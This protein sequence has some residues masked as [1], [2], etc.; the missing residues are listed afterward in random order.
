MTTNPD[1]LAA[2]ETVAAEA[3]FSGLV[4]IDRPGLP[5]IDRAIGLAD[6]RWQVPVRPDSIL[7]IA[8]GAKGFTALTVMSLV[9]DGHA[10]ARHHGA[11][12]PRRRPAA[13]R[14]RR[15][16]PAPA[17]PP[18]RHRRLPR[19]D[20][21]ARRH[22]LRPAGA[23]AIDTSTPRT[24]SPPSTAI[25]P[26]FP[27]DERFAYNN[28]G[29]VLLAILAE[30][31]AGVPYH[32]LVHDRV[33]APAGMV[34]TAFQRSDAPQPRTR[35]RLPGRPTGLRTNQ[36]HMPLRGVGDG[37]LF[38]TLADMRSFWAALLAGRIVPPDV[39][40][41]MTLPRSESTGGR[42]AIRPRVL[43]AGRRRRDPARG[44]RRGHLVPLDVPAVDWRGRRR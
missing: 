35:D 19:R 37:G 36:L 44:L 1:W 2:L 32:Q 27:A 11:L 20:S 16:G 38:T 15:H 8:S 9:T 42:P 6:R 30:R 24:T 39:L 13:R 22:R 3:S 29:F 17:R 12:A 21:D 25:P 31:A 23:R 18:L 4:G 5:P 41:E 33:I 10:V 7:A 34:D 14:R 40:A 28:G 26:V 43:A